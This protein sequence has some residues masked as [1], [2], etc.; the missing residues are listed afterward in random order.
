MPP[1][2][3]LKPGASPM[4]L[5]HRLTL[6]LAAITVQ[7]MGQPL[8]NIDL[9][10]PTGPPEELRR[11]LEF[12]RNAVSYEALA[13]LRQHAEQ[14]RQY[15]SRQQEWANGF[16]QIVTR[17]LSSDRISV[18]AARAL[19]AKIATI[20]QSAEFVFLPVLQALL[21]YKGKVDLLS[22]QERGALLP[23]LDLY[24]SAVRTALDVL[25][26]SRFQL[27]S[28][29]IERGGSKDDYQ[30]SQDQAEYVLDMQAAHVYQIVAERE[31]H[32]K[33]KPATKEVA[34]ETYRVLEIYV[35]PCIERPHR[36]YKEALDRVHEKVKRTH[37]ASVGRIGFIFKRS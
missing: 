20:E 32:L 8:H 7:S 18:P 12:V 24:I 17:F 14:I 19:E 3:D 10:E 27:S 31:L 6:W 23:L 37:P 2:E 13:E 16:S 25:R 1:S 26:F 5:S 22:Q 29:L 11:P 33:C 4:R 15:A 9:S 30:I 36:Y 28:F 21:V 35:P 34:G